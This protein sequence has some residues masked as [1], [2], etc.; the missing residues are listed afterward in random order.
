MSFVRASTGLPPLDHVLGGGLVPAAVVL[1]VS[2]PGVGKTTLTLQTLAGLGH[3]C[4][5]T[6]GEET[7][8]HVERTAHRIGAV[9]P[10]VFVLAERNLTRVFAHAR[11]IRAQTIAIDSI[12][13]LLCEDVHGR[14]GS[15]PQLKACVSQLVRYAKTHDTTLWLIGHV[16]GDGDIAGPK[17]IEHEVDV[18]LKLSRG[19]KFE[20]NERSL[21]CPHKNRFGPSNV[22]GSFEL[23]A[24]GFVPVSSSS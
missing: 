3:Q 10:Q 13:T 17:T 14:A 9:R 11:E 5:Y 15:L 16:T 19:A 7:V 22:V 20:G 18:V 23:T 24:Q 12:Q 8:E 2:P 21:H 4:L 1:L 6:T